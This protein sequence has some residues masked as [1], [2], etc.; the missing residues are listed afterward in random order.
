MSK[1][2]TKKNCLK[3][4][5]AAQT[6]LEYINHHVKRS[7]YE[8]YVY[9]LNKHILPYFGELDVRKITCAVINDFTVEKLTSG[10]IK[11]NGGLSK[12]YLQ[13]ILSIVK[14]IVN[15]C[16]QEYGIQSKIHKTRGL[17]VKKTEMKI[18][19]GSERKK[20]SKLL[21]TGKDPYNIG[22]MLSLYTGIRIGEVCG[23]KWGDFNEAEATITIRRTVQ[24]ISDNNGSTILLV[25]E[26][27]TEAA[28]R[29]IPLPKFL[30]CMLSKMKKSPEKTI[31]S[32]TE[33]YA[34][35]SELRRYF[36][37]ILKQCNIKEVRYH[38][39]RHTFASNCVQLKFDTKTLSEILGH[40]SVNMTLNRY[41]HTSLEIKRKYMDMI[42]M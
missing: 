18:L 27:K 13:D 6:W 26:P 29:V 10:K 22:I 24:R 8:N 37:N 19:N 3:F 12:K 31:L 16:E 11:R 34:E 41:V 39:L 14:S 15:F 5:A 28:A 21:K 2:N 4:A 32:G 36:K 42:Y 38:D 25:G 23:L 33:E 1:R 35:P 20:L 30:C 40:T 7:T 9:L 17:K